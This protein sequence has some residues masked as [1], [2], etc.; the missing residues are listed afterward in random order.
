MAHHQSFQKIIWALLIYLPKEGGYP[1]YWLHDKSI[2]TRRTMMVESIVEFQLNEQLSIAIWPSGKT[3]VTGIAWSKLLAGLFLPF[4]H[5]YP[6]LRGS[7][8]AR[9][10]CHA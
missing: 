9:Q 8:L 7:K 2:L 4:H 6:G 3:Q 1:E 10:E 5:H